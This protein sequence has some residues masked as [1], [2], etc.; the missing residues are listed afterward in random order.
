MYADVMEAYANETSY[1]RLKHTAR[2][3]RL[4]DLDEY[5]RRPPLRGAVRRARVD[6]E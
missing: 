4:P 2:P 3:T 6:G 5:D 1:A